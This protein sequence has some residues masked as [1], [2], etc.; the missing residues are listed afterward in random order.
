MDGFSTIERL[1]WYNHTHMM[2]QQPLLDFGAAVVL[3]CVRVISMLP[4]RGLMSMSLGLD[5]GIG[6][7]I[8]PSAQASQRAHKHMLQQPFSPDVGVPAGVDAGIE[9]AFHP[10]F[11]NSARI[12]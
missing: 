8:G 5:V 10:P 6:A 11:F 3:C 7:G 2:V 4:V 12:P 9:D 1:L